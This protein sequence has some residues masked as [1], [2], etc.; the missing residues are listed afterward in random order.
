VVKLLM[1]IYIVPRTHLVLS[2]ITCIVVE[3]LVISSQ[4][5]VLLSSSE[6]EAVLKGLNGTITL[7]EIGN[8]I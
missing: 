1:V 2:T 8:Q 6:S 7:D 4:K 3:F 5:S